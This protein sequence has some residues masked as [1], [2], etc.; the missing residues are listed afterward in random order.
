MIQK[1][2]QLYFYISFSFAP[3]SGFIGRDIRGVYISI[4]EEVKRFVVVVWVD[5]FFYFFF[6]YGD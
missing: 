5:T 6:C 4:W 3:P 1:G 2:I